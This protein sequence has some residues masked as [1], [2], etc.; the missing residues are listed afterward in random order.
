MN[1]NS[2][3]RSNRNYRTL[4]YKTQRGKNF[5]G[6]NL[7]SPKNNQEIKRFKNSYRW[8]SNSRR[9]DFRLQSYTGRLKNFTAHFLRQSDYFRTLG[10]KF[11]DYDQG[12][13]GGGGLPPSPR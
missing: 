3:Q 10:S 1:Y 4:E 6:D 9:H 2:E 8:P 12:V 11:R 7:K 5:C 13:P